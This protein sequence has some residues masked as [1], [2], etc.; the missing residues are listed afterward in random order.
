ML[1]KQDLLVGYSFAAIPGSL[2]IF[3]NSGLLQM[4]LKSLVKFHLMNSSK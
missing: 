1:V 4:N 2:G 3:T